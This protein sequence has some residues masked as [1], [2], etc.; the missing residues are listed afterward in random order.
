MGFERERYFEKEGGRWTQFWAVTLDGKKVEQRLGDMGVLGQVKS[1]VYTSPAEAK[2]DLEKLVKDHEK[3]G[4]EEV[5]GS[6]VYVTGKG[7]RP[8][9]VRV[10]LDEK[11]VFLTGYD[12]VPT[13]LD[14]SPLQKVKSMRE[15]H[16]QNNAKLKSIDVRPILEH[17]SLELITVD[18]ALEVVGEDECEIEI[19]RFD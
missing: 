13:Q 7:K 4:F 18:E 12:S 5:A 10:A 9:A 8:L 2:S 14:L 17:P 6:A 16:L 11:E 1:K 3:A 15:L 19:R